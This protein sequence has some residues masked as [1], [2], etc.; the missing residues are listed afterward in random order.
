M[1]D[2]QGNSG[3]CQASYT[4]YP[5]PTIATNHTT[6]QTTLVPA[7]CG[8]LTYP[9]QSLNVT[10]I[11]NN[12]PLTQMA[13]TDQC[14]DISVT[15]LNGTPPFVLTVAPTYHPPLNI[16]SDSM[17]PINWT[18]TLG[19]AHQYYLSLV[20]SQGLSWS[21]GPLHSG[22]NGLTDC[23]VLGGNSLGIR[24]T[25]ESRHNVSPGV[26]AGASVAA[27]VVGIMI[28]GLTFWWIAARRRPVPASRIVKRHSSVTSQTSQ[29]EHMNQYGITPY[30]ST[31]EPSTMSP[32]PSTSTD[33]ISRAASPPGS[34]PAQVGRSLSE[35]TA[36]QV[37]VVHHDGG[38]PPI[39][40][41]HTEGAEVVEL[42]PSYGP[43]TP[44][45]APLAQS[46]RAIRR[47]SQKMRGSSS[48][49]VSN[50]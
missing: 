9:T 2:S 7:T 10:G 8:N 38:R 4:V 15:P 25:L 42:P 44:V 41:Y 1:V 11:D 5:N 31:P 45:D 35:R 39:S 30:P 21:I 12:G 22:G 16:T 29:R 36:P 49:T 48:R 24:A 32:D 14:N 37:Y 13:W 18:V 43:G 46:A 40:V 6:N 50:N 34:P 47:L 26:A 33:V 23:L 17:K 28:G 3:G 27:L 20:D 19:W